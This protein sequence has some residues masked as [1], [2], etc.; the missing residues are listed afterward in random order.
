MKIFIITFLFLIPTILYAQKT[1]INSKGK[2][3][4]GAEIG[5]NIIKS[6][7]EKQYTK[8]QFGISSEYYFEKNWSFI[9]K[10]KYFDTAVS[11]NNGKDIPPSFVVFFADNQRTTP[12]DSLDF[13][14]KVIAVPIQIKY[15]MDLIKQVKFFTTLGFAYNLEIESRYFVPNDYETLDQ[16]KFN[17]SYVNLNLGVGLT[18]FLSKSSALFINSEYFRFGGAKGK[19]SKNFFSLTLYEPEN[20]FVTIGFKYNFKN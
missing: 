6:N 11:Y 14:G 5:M 19:K 17:K 16:K 13:E 15:E 18:Y 8:L 9:T 20:S 3:F 1:N 7:E 2:W 10:I 4:F 12:Y